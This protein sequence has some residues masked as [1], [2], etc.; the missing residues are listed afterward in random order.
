MSKVKPMKSSKV[1]RKVNGKGIR[2]GKPGMQKPKGGNSGA[3]G[4]SMTYAKGC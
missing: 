4:N 2:G 1:V 3:Y